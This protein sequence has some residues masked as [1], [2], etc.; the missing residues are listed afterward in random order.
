MPPMTVQANVISDGV[1]TF[2]HYITSLN[3][4]D[5][6]GGIRSQMFTGFQFER[7]RYIDYEN[8]VSQADAN[9]GTDD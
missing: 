8:G 9:T 2:A 1:K 7:E 4:D 5:I 6:L 3:T